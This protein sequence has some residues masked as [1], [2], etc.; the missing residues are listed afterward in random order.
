MIKLD[1]YSL[2]IHLPFM[3]MYIAVTKEAKGV[4]VFGKYIG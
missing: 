4:E 3:T 1:E 2:D